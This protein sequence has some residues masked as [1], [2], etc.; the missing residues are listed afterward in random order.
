MYLLL[1]L[2]VDEVGLKGLFFREVSS[3]TLV[4]EVT[5]FSFV[6]EVESMVASS[7]MLLS[8]GMISCATGVTDS[9]LD[10]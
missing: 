8:D 7:G 1:F 3:L 6:S 10:F 9:P 4:I 2:G 5:E